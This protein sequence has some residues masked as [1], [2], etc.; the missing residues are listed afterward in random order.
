[1]KP[2]LRPLVQ[3][4][5]LE[6]DGDG[7]D[8]VHRGA[9][10][11]DS[12]VAALTLIGTGAATRATERLLRAHDVDHVVVIGIAGGVP[13]AVSLGDVLVPEV[14]IDAASGHEHR[15][16]RLGDAELR[17][18]VRTSD[19]LGVDAAALLADGVDACDMETAAIAAVCEAHGRPW[20]AFRA[21]SDM[22]GGPVD[23]AVLA[24]ANPD[25]TGNL[26]AAARYLLPRPWK[27]PALARL[28][29]DTTVATNAAASAAI[30]ACGIDMR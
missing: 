15:A 4:L 30:R 17:G 22:V 1:M 20:T 28:A 27:I 6:R 12:V 9:F 10:G 14:V 19:D 29:R 24:M 7:D 8:S 11:A 13:S 23:D 5:K 16:S 21:I 26:R 25:G 3:R 2:E 18:R